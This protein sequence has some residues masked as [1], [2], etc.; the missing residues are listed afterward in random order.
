MTQNDI[1]RLAVK[2]GAYWEH[3]DWNMPSA[4]I[5]NQHGLRCGTGLR[6]HLM[7]SLGEK[8]CMQA[9]QLFKGESK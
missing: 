7:R 4:V 6:R 1:F 8:A 9:D 3:G 2:A 5:F